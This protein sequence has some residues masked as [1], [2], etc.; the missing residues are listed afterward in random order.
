MTS[1]VVLTAALRNNL[2][3]LQNTQGLIDTTQLRLATGLK[4]N[5]ALDN[6]QNFFA[7]SALN[8]RA[9]DLQRLLDGIGQN[10]Q[11][12]KAADNGVTALTRLVEQ[13]ESV[14]QSARDIVNQ[15][16]SEARV[17]GSKD[18]SGI[19]DLTS[20]AG[21]NA[22]DQLFIEVIDPDSDQP[23][24]LDAAD[25]S[26]ST[27]ALTITIS[28]GDSINELLTKINDNDNIAE[29][30]I[31][32]SLNSDGELEI[33]TLNGGDFQ[34]DFVT[35]GDTDAENLAL[36][37]AVGLGQVARV[38]QDGTGNN[39][40]QFTSS[41][42][43]AI[44][45]F[46]L[47]RDATQ[48]QRALG[49]STLEGLFDDQG[50]QVFSGLATAG[51]AND[52]FTISV[53]GGTSISIDL[54][55]LTIQGFV[56]SINDNASLNDLIEANFDEATSQISIRSID[57][58]VQD[59]TI[60]VTADAA[61][62]ADFGFGATSFSALAG[63]TLEETIR[64]G[65]GAA[66]LAELENDFDTVKAQIDE[67]VTNGDTGYR[68]A[69]LLDGDDL[70][71]FFNEFRSSSL[72]TEGV[73]FT[74]AGLGI[75]DATFSDA[76]TIDVQLSE[77]REALETVRNFGTTLANDLAI[78]QTREDF[79]KQII[80]TLE[81]GADKLTVADQ[82]EEGAKLLALQTRQQLGVTSLAGAGRHIGEYVGPARSPSILSASFK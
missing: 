28:A 3:S 23:V 67:L 10:I 45:S 46:E 36:A 81:E 34:V 44:K 53:D 51:T 75:N 2:L 61:D 6:P 62:D 15:G 17:E 13:A 80:N 42:D 76:N 7:A 59:I 52:V 66:R 40:V 69:N 5:S 4:V 47:F 14:A 32:A 60:G 50:N 78:I 49:S 33:R 73:N 58:E 82:N 35:G 9:S 8:N 65:A 57:A 30:V 39:N 77:V 25:A 12:I 1:D 56:D 70:V 21:I 11:T 37:E 19:A 79:T 43:N 72:T 54:N 16:S 38:V 74:S 27:T 48:T 22:G 29:P 41:A 64:F 63:N 20:L 71:T 31:E 55:G 68:G 18:L 26:P 24:D